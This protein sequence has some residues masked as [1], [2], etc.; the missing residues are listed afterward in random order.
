MSRQHEPPKIE[1]VGNLHDRLA[2]VVAPRCQICRERE[3]T[4]EI[5]A[6]GTALACDEC[7]DR[8][9]DNGAAIG[10]LVAHVPIGGDEIPAEVPPE[11]FAE[12]MNANAGDVE[13]ARARAF[14]LFAE[15]PWK[16]G[17][18]LM[19]EHAKKNG[20]SR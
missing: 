5:L 8:L 18:E 12:V 3:A 9:Q 10:V 1:H 4:R 11:I 20:G 13:R 15:G 7:A 14:P 17:L 2:A 16:A 19:R 6:P